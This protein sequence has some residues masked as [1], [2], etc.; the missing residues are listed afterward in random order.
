MSV[1]PD[2]LPLAKC[3]EVGAP[4]AELAI[5]KP[6]LIIGSMARTEYRAVLTIAVVAM[7]YKREDESN[8]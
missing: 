6:R 1:L 4:D 2:P 3:S 8:C 5:A 7:M